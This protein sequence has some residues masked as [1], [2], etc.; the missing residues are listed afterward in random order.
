MRSLSFFLRE[1]INGIKRHSTSSLVT[2]LQVFIS[3]FFLGLC[4][5]FII[6]VNHFVDNF[7]NNLEMGAF[8][9]EEVD[10]EQAVTLMD[11]IDDLPGV[12]AITY[13]S[14]EEAFSIMQQRT[15]MDISDLVRANPL[16]ASLKITVTS[17]RA[18]NELAE[19]IGLLE[20][21]ED[22]RYGEAQLQTLL[23]IFFGLELISFFWVVFT[24]GA[25]LMTIVN[26]IRL[27]ILARKNEIRIMQLV[28]ATSWFIRLPFMIEGMIY[29]L[30][31]AALAL[32]LVGVTY[33]VLL[34]GIA[35]RNIFNPWVIDL[36]LMIY[37][38]SI[39][40]FFLGG[41]IGIIASLI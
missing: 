5:I 29:G 3:L 32:V 37:N 41:L 17:P 39:I 34:L 4:L 16:P 20:G 28:G 1:T 7:L 15:T 30:G 10:Y 21:I 27:A 35:A 8:L 2:F 33:D 38:L 36:G 6:N 26:T 12:R 13:I 22:V 31:G 40:L 19:T 23:P 11:I 24:A 9:K 25:T 18:A 14:K